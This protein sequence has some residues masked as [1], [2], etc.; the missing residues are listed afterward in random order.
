MPIEVAH[1]TRDMTESHVVEKK[2]TPIHHQRWF[3]AVLIAFMALSG[4]HVTN[5]VMAWNNSWIDP[6][7]LFEDSPSP[8]AV[9]ADIPDTQD[10]T[11]TLL[12]RRLI[13]S[14]SRSFP[15]GCCL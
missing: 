12:L 14:L 4:L 6:N 7:W 15:P 3:W 10:G 8:E 9:V 13:A 2:K 11:E 1:R 5:R